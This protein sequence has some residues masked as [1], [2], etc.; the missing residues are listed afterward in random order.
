MSKF[1]SV[2]AE[3][4]KLSAL[5]LSELVKALEE[6]FGISAAAP[7]AAGGGAGA[8]AAEEKTSFNVVLKSGG[9]SKLNVIKVVRE[10]LGLGLAD[11]KAFVADV[12]AALYASKIVS[13]AQGY[14][15]MRSAAAEYKWNL[16]YGGIAL[17]AIAIGA[18]AVVL[19]LGLS[20]MAR[21]GSPHRSQWSAAGC[22]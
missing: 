10:L 3:I 15:L 9:A 14:M 1:D 22:R 12:E 13:Y 11:A 5:E 18:V 6:K 20:N 16:N 17:M 4:E 19:L 21:G 8:A 2:I 7:V